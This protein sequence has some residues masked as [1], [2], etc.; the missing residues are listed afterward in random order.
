MSSTATPSPTSTSNNNNPSLASSASLY[1]YTFLAT[2]VLL[3]SVSAAIILRSLLMRRRHRRM[4]EEAIRNGTW[5]PPS[6]GG[7]GFG[8]GTRSARDRIDPAKKPKMWDAFVHDPKIYPDTDWSWDSIRPFSANVVT[9]PQQPSPQ[10]VALQS[11]TEPS[12]TRPPLMQRIRQYISPSPPA[13]LLSPL[14]PPPNN[15][16]TPPENVLS[17]GPQTL[18]V[19]FL[20]AMPL[21]SHASISD[22][23][24]PIPPLPKN[25][26]GALPY[27][28]FGVAELVVG[29][30][31]VQDTQVGA[32][33]E[34]DGK[35]PLSTQSSME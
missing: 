21:Q 31:K 32:R 28:E 10:T 14:P 22:S 20:I 3:L 19:S 27:I 30:E 33:G 15:E 5:I 34:V 17:S 29:K 2:L 11:S 24:S 7:L 26:D 16:S 4:V 23:P 9:P 6:P 35:R 18:R 1:L 13:F 25:Q 12:I 8:F